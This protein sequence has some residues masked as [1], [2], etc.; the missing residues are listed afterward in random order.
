[1]QEW[2]AG[3]NARPSEDEE[4]SFLIHVAHAVKDLTEGE[5]DDN[6]AGIGL[7][8]KDQILALDFLYGNESYDVDEPAA[9]IVR[10]RQER[11]GT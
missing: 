9:E 11:A 4:D 2:E 8:Q 1:M 3:Y 7:S 6:F 10:C 5:Y